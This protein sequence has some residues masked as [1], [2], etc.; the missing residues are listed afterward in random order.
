MRH[1]A[2]DRDDVG[3]AC[4]RCRVGE[5]GEDREESVPS[6]TQIVQEPAGQYG[7]EY[8][9]I[10]IGGQARVHIGDTVNH[11]HNPP[12]PQTDKYETLLASLTFD[13]MDARLRNVATALP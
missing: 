10:G 12:R 1:S 9:N 5:A 11:Y 7:H 4:E 8:G 2:A 3:R 6:P 13:R